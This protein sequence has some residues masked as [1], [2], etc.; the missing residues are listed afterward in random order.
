MT[1]RICTYGVLAAL[2]MV[3]GFIEG[4]L[5]LDVIAPG[6]KLGL[7][8]TV[9]LLL[10]TVGDRKGA[11]AVNLTR[12]CLSALLFGSPVSFAFS[13]AGGLGS[14]CLMSILSRFRSFSPVGIGIAGGAVHNLF[15]LAVAFVLIGKSIFLY[16]PLLVAVGGIC[17]G[18]VGSLGKII[19]KKMQTN[20]KN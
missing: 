14:L 9:A 15:Q 8:N 19:F 4:F 16:L 2:C 13:L 20:G 10:I 18:L 17:G 3:L 7:A 1:K 11:F 12:I 5:P 6:I